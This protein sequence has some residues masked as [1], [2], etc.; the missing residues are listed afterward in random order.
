MDLTEL[1][2]ENVLFLSRDQNRQMSKIFLLF[3]LSLFYR[4]PL[5]T[6][7]YALVLLS[8]YYDCTNACKEVSAN[9]FSSTQQNTEYTFTACRV[10]MEVVK[11]SLVPG[12]VIE[13]L[14]H[15]CM[16]MTLTQA[17]PQDGLPVSKSCH[18]PKSFQGLADPGWMREI[19]GAAESSIHVCKNANQL[20]HRL[21]CLRVRQS[22]G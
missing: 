17:A 10:A 7:M 1:Y 18:N 21:R 3:L 11:M 14:G 9:P 22:R 4:N 6:T 12:Q 13:F 15:F 16:E 8:N 20:C 19:S 5:R 2:V